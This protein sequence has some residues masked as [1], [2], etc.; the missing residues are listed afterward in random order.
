VQAPSVL[1]PKLLT[2]LGDLELVARVTVDGA[3]S[4]LHE[5]PFHG[6][7]AEFHQYRHYRPGDDLKYVDWKLFA[8]TDR[9]YTKQYQE[10]ANLVAQV[11]VDA[12]R[13][14]AFDGS[15][16]VSKLAYARVMAA[17]LAHLIASQGDAVGLAIYDEAI[18]EYVPSRSGQTHLRRVLAALSKMEASGR[19]SAA[20][21]L[22]RAVDLLKRRG[23]VLIISD[24]YDEDDV[25]RELKRAVRIGHEVA[26]FHVL[27]REELEF[28]YGGEVE[29][30]DLE[31]GQTRLAGPGARTSYRREFAEFLERWR[32]RCARYRIDYTRMLTDAS[33]DTALR[34]YLLRRVGSGAR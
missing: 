19:T 18:R 10:T 21:A 17:A 24:L 12:S 15:A 9:F 29:L 20:A 5:S 16:R 30:E 1:D 34:G 2:S 6:Y 28:P 4:G 32:T 11:V 13:S 7:S 8:R 31:S 14:M 3:S 33:L 22:R 26:L 27:T 23:L 25:E